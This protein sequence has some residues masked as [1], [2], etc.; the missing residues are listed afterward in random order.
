M[1]SD[2]VVYTAK[3]MY[4]SYTNYNKAVIESAYSFH[5]QGNRLSK[6]DVTETVIEHF[7]GDCRML[8]PEDVVYMEVRYRLN[9]KKYRIID[10]VRIQLPYTLQL[11]VISVKA[12]GVENGHDYSERFAKYIGP[13]GDCHGLEQMCLQEFFPS[14]SPEEVPE[15]IRIEV[16]KSILG[17]SGY[18]T[19]YQNVTHKD[20]FDAYLN[21]S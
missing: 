3:E 16:T 17:V 18:S 19:V 4:Q 8:V 9:G 6:E 20:P 15:E 21:F 7:Q 5:N 13:W 12:T 2:T 11:P 14:W 1:I 10:R